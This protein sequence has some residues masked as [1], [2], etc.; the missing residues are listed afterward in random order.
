[1]RI[2]EVVADAEHRAALTAVA[3]DH[4][5]EAEEL[6]K[7][8]RQSGTSAGPAADSA[9]TIVDSTKSKGEAE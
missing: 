1:M 8:A 7:V 4:L 9:Q 3:A 5:A 2:A 6:E